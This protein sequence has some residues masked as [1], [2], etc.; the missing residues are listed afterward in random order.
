[1]VREAAAHPE[2]GGGGGGGRGQRRKSDLGHGEGTHPTPHPRHPAGREGGKGWAR[3]E[4]ATGRAG[5]EGS[6]RGRTDQRRET[7]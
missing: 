5:R 3:V 6:E 2:G 7:R 1:M 4:W